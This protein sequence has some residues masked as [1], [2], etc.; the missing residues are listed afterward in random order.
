MWNDSNKYSHTPLYSPPYDISSLN[1]ILSVHS[2]PIEAVQDE[3]ATWFKPE[4]GK[5]SE[6][7][8]NKR[9][10]QS[11]ETTEQR[12]VRLSHADALAMNQRRKAKDEEIY[13]GLTFVPAI[14][15]VLPS[16]FVLSPLISS[17]TLTS[18]FVSSPSPPSP[19]ISTSLNHT[20]VRSD[21]I[22]IPPV[23]RLTT[24]PLS[25]P[26]PPPLHTPPPHP[27]II[28]HHTHTYTHPLFTGIQSSRSFPQPQR[29]GRKQKRGSGERTRETSRKKNGRRGIYI[30]TTC[31][32]ISCT[33]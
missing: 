9:P 29:I 27:L 1:D 12:V 10:S 11:S 13:G 3:G 5:S 19:L 2:I 8:A 24:H 18:P 21:N 28:P 26:P 25:T 23:D 32:K 15:P 33:V 4:I 22:T 20:F 6:I 17:P 14:D 7:I 16:P 30:Q 31:R